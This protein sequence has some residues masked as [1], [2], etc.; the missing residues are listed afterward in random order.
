MPQSIFGRVRSLKVEF[1]SIAVIHVLFDAARLS[2]RTGRRHPEPNALF[3]GKGGTTTVDRVR[4]ASINPLV[5][6]NIHG[7]EKN[8]EVETS[9][10]RRTE[11]EAKQKS[12]SS[13][14]K[15]NETMIASIRS[16]RR[17]AAKHYKLV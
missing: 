8:E 2:V 10:N 13:R 7:K 9:V 17:G 11:A 6:G 16:S 4:Y 12:L 3:E 15:R 5:C 14:K 1:S